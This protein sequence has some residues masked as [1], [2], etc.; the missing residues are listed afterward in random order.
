[1][2]I[3]WHLEKRYKTSWTIVID[4]GRDPATGKQKR[5]YRSVKCNKK[6]AEQEAIRLV[7]EIQAG[8]YTAPEKTTLNQ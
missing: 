8:M 2:G 3:S 6:Q 7:A 1:M 4:L 5:I